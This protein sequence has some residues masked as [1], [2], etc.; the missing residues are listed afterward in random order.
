MER[1]RE[2]R[3]KAELYR[4]MAEQPTE[5]GKGADRILL[6]LAERMDREADERLAR[7]NASPETRQLRR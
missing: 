6:K 1:A 7:L 5:G 3:Q 2:L 4:R